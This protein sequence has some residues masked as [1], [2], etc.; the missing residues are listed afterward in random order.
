[1]AKL[2]DWVTRQAAALGMLLAYELEQSILL[3]MHLCEHFHELAQRK[4][5]TAEV[6]YS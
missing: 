1:V 4:S 6:D 2:K 5:S 3:I